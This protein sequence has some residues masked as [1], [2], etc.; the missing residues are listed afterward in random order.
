MQAVPVGS[1][2]M[3]QVLLR[4]VLPRAHI[5]K[6]TVTRTDSSLLSITEI[7]FVMAGNM[8]QRTAAST[9]VARKQS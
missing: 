6:R 8:W 1:R 2:F 3:I 7:L 9:L 4:L 5:P